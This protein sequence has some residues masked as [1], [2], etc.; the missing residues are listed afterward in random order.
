MC[1]GTLE[2]FSFSRTNRQACHELAVSCRPFRAFIYREMCYIFPGQAT[3]VWTISAARMDG[4][5]VPVTRESRMSFAGE[6]VYEKFTLSQ[7]G[8]GDIS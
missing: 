7:Q 6:T 2:L 4:H 5:A 1:P 3:G 8:Q